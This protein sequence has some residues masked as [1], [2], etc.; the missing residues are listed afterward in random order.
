MKKIYP[1]IIVI[2]LIS[3]STSTAIFS[4]DIKPPKF[5]VIPAGIN[6]WF[7]GN[8]SGWY[9]VENETNGFDVLGYVKGYY[10]SQSG[11][12]VGQWNTSY[13]TV[14]GEMIGFWGEKFFIA[15]ITISIGNKIQIGAGLPA[16]GR[17]ELNET[18]H[19]FKAQIRRLL[20][21][22]IHIFCECYKSQE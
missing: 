20:K 2:L 21:P 6:D 14:S 12:F 3:M 17:C 4:Q 19:E 22:T 7:D 16:I 13:G 9:G 18:T 11:F 8:F 1:F 5:N 10:N 15:L